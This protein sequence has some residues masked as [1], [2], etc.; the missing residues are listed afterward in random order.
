[1][2]LWRVAASLTLGRGAVQVVVTVLPTDPARG[3]GAAGE[4]HDDRVIRRSAAGPSPFPDPPIRPAF[5][6]SHSPS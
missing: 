1:M 3:K 5:A 4:G 6:E 2:R